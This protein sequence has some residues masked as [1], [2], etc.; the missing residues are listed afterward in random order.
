MAQCLLCIV[1]STC[2]SCAVSQQGLVFRKAVPCALPTAFGRH[3]SAGMHPPFLLIPC[4]QNHQLQ[5]RLVRLGLLPSK[6]PRLSQRQ[7]PCLMPH[8]RH[9]EPGNFACHV[10]E[11]VTQTTRNATRYAY[12]RT[13]VPF[14]CPE[15]PRSPSWQ[16]RWRPLWPGVSWRFGLVDTVVS[17]GFK[18]NE[19]D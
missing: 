12:R 9:I 11:G 2:F 16:G 13:A 5:I 18:H 10:R 8:H 15:C 17:K 6:M 14:I 4:F 19:L 7:K 1:Y 3:L